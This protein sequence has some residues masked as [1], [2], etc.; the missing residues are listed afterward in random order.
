MKFN[1]DARTSNHA[2]EIIHGQ[3]SHS[4]GRIRL[5]TAFYLKWRAIFKIPWQ[6]A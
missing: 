1:A 6:P 4:A 2:G 5:D 3:N